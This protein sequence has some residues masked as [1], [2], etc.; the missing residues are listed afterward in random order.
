MISSSQCPHIERLHN[1]E[2]LLRRVPEHPWENRVVFNPA[3]VLVDDQPTLK[4]VLRA[5]PMDGAVV[6]R[7]AQQGPLCLLYYRA[8]G[9]PVRGHD[10]RRSTIGLAVLSAELELLARLDMPVL[11]PDMPYEDLGV[12]DPRITR[13]GD[14][15][16]MMYAA[17]GSGSDRNRIRIACASSTNLVHWEKHGLL[18]GD[19]NAVDNKNAVLFPMRIGGR[20]QMF[21]RPMEGTDAMMMH[22]AEADDL[23]G[24]WTSTGVFMRP[25]AD[26]AFKDVWIGGGAPPLLV[27]ENTFL[28]LYHIGKRKVDGRREYDLGIALVDSRHPEVVLRRDEPLLRP[29]SAAETQGDVDLGVNNVVFVCGAFLYRGDLYIPYAGAD[30]VVLGARIRKAEIDR[31]LRTSSAVP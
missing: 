5:L 12:E 31:Y 30:S 11:R 25:V 22:R 2:P 23:L 1:G 27:D 24:E 17:Y 7:L 4:K 21:H 20:F 29:E 26:P 18:K 13:L 15:F 6:Q 16:F 14:R 9:E 28:V 3:A 19:V 8:Q 10:H